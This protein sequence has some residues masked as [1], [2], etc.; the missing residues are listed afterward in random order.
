MV[1]LDK[2]IYEIDINDK[3]FPEK[4]RIIDNPP[5]KL[6]A[7]GDISLLNK[8]SIA[9]VGSRKCSEYG[10][11]IAMRIGK[12]AVNNHLVVVSG[13]AKGIDAYG[14]LGALK[15][16]GKT[17]AVLGSGVDVCYPA[18]NKNIYDEIANRGLII[19]E[20]PPGTEALPF[21]FPQ[22]N[23]IISA[24]SEAVC[25]V[26]A[27]T[28]SGALITAEIANQQGKH[29]FA[30]PGNITS[31][32]SLGSNKLITDGAT[33]IAVI[34]DIFI[35]IGIEPKLIEEET[36]NLG[37]AEKEVY[38][39]IKNHGEIS[40]D[41]ICESLGKSAVDVNALV[42]ILEIKGLVCYNF[43]KIFVAK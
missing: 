15:V 26:E 12:S 17:I 42:S 34:D 4:L 41:Y 28:N 23:R 35:G 39:F 32:F 38:A 7:K 22:R 11:T 10:K 16:A 6:Y 13:M 2:G 5:K 25:V 36:E 31:Q 27:A 1:L 29:V 18:S 3:E 8:K 43:G 19:S 21:M 40:T 9:I 30:V 20:Q 37:E 14:H 24:L 33:P